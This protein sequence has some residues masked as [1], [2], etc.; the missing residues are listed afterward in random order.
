M[1][2]DKKTPAVV[3]PSESALTN[4]GSSPAE[5]STETG[6]GGSIRDKIHERF[7]RMISKERSSDDPF[8]QVLDVI[9][10]VE[11]KEDLVKE[12]EIKRLYEV[13][14]STY[15][16]LKR[17]FTNAY[18]LFYEIEEALDG[19]WVVSPNLGQWRPVGHMG[20][21][22]TFAAGVMKNHSPTAP[23]ADKSLSVTFGMGDYK[24]GIGDETWLGRQT[25]I[26]DELTGLEDCR[27]KSITEQY[28]ASQKL[29]NSLM[30]F[31]LTIRMNHKQVGQKV[32][33]IDLASL[34]RH[35]L[36]QIC[37]GLFVGLNNDVLMEIDPLA[38]PCS[39]VPLLEAIS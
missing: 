1:F 17:E 19:W 30:S 6:I 34:E 23:L 3:P 37:Q 32:A 4:A 14:A 16:V 26:S 36:R 21:G 31:K 13:W 25:P 15:Y 11:K 27:G 2:Q 9:D 35:S 10:A 29:Y 38:L 22:Y 7:K 24:C 39:S 8:N 12:E 18:A 28:E 33:E 20:N 5:V